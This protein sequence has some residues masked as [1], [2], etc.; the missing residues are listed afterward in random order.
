MLES[1]ARV[2]R[3]KFAE[4]LYANLCKFYGE[5]NFHV[6]GFNA[7]LLCY[8]RG[9]LIKQAFQKINERP[10][11]WEM[12][13]NLSYYLAEACGSTAEELDK[14]YYYLEDMKKKG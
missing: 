6:I 11:E 13:Y 10:P 3:F 14:N 2:A 9:K 4:R 5:N 8:A 12:N 7:L 1:A